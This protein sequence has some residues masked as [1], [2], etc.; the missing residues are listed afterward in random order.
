MQQKES[1][2]ESS[3]IFKHYPDIC[4]EGL[5]K[6]MTTPQYIWC[7]GSYLNTRQSKYE[8]GLSRDHNHPTTDLLFCLC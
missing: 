3:L 5:M 1:E 4:L 8:A 7:L 2:E 6:A